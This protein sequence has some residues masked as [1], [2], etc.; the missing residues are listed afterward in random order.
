MKYIYINW[1]K[2]EFL[3][4][5]LAKIIKI[6]GFIPDLIVGLARGGLLI[7]RLLSDYLEVTEI[8]ILQLEYY[9]NLNEK[10]TIPSLISDI[11]C[12]IKGKNI[13][14]CDDLIDTGKSMEFI[15]SY[16][17]NKGCKNIRSAT[18]YTKPHSKFLPDYSIEEIDG[19][20]VFPWELNETIKKLKETIKSISEL[21]N[22]LLNLG[23]ENKLLKNIIDL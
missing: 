6:D 15:L 7:A 11:T 4:I 5:K 22:M 1:S 13:L 3:C 9:K 23:I 2:I 12:D 21:E 14:I 8:G 19:W 20:V 10:K 18:L 17:K 16:I